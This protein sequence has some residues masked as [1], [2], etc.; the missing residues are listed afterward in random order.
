MFRVEGAK[1][2]DILDERIQFY[3]QG[4][5]CHLVEQFSVLLFDV[6][7]SHV[8]EQDVEAYV[9]NEVTAV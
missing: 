1:L 4:R 2:Y 8:L 6:V 9:V 7:T 3:L 5:A